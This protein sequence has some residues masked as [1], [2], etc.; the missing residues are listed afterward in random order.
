[1]SFTVPRR[2]R[3][4]AHGLSDRASLGVRVTKKKKKKKKKK[5]RRKKKKKKKRKEKKKY[6]QGEPGTRRV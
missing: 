4:E 3:L 2:A 5:R 6:P 1:M